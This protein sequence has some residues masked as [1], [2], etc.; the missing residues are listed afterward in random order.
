MQFDEV[1]VMC[2]FWMALSLINC[3]CIE[4]QLYFGK[5]LPYFTFYLNFGWLHKGFKMN[6]NFVLMIHNYIFQ[7]KSEV[8]IL[9]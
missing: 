9:Q 6:P 2:Y 5:A 8:I 4:A 7:T 1:L 3:F